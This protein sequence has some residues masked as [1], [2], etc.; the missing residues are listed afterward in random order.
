MGQKGWR[1][2]RPSLRVGKGHEVQLRKELCAGEVPCGEA[3]GVVRDTGLV[4]GR[5]RD[6]ADA[7]SG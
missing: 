4:L 1:R 2:E 5:R 7:G 6:D 3:A